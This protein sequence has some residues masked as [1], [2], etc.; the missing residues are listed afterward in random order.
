MEKAMNKLTWWEFVDSLNKD[1]HPI[2]QF[3][4]GSKF[5]RGLL[6]FVSFLFGLLI[7]MKEFQRSNWWVM[8]FVFGFA[9]FMDN[10]TVSLN[11]D[12]Q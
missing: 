12:E 9:W 6:L 10:L 3:F 1:R 7:G 11:G 5:F 8:I 2:I 4:F